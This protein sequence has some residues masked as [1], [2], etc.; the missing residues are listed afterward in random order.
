MVIVIDIMGDSAEHDEAVLITDVDVI[1]GEK[2]AYDVLLPE[3]QLIPI[4]NVPDVN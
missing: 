3:P 1:E 2:H 4:D